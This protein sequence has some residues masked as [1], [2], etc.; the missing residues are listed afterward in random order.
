MSLVETR[1]A[2]GETAM[3]LTTNLFESWREYSRKRQERASHYKTLTAVSDLPPHLL[4]DIGWPS[5]Y[6]RGRR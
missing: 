2:K 3:K 4:K 6:E 5:A 1:N